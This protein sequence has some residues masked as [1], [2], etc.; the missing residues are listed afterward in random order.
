M[1]HIPLIQIHTT[2][3]RLITHHPS[4]ITQLHP[5]YR[6]ISRSWPQRLLDP[7]SKQR[8][9]DIDDEIGNRQSAAVEGPFGLGGEGGEGDLEGDGVGVEGEPVDFLAGQQE[10]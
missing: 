7:F 9:G 2:Q 6:E 3:R 5:R 4:L 8:K 10:S 1:H